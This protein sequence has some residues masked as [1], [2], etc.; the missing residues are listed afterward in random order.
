[1]TLRRVLITGLFAILSY[2]SGI[3]EE[4]DVLYLA[5]SEEKEIATKEGEKVIVHGISTDSTKSAS[6][7]N[8]VNFDGSDFYLVTFASDLDQFENGEPHEIYNEKRIAVEGVISIYK[9]KPQIKLT[10]PDQILILAD[11]EVFPPVK[12]EIKEAESEKMKE[13]PLTP[14]EPKEEAPR[15]KPPVDWKLYFK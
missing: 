9:G 15:P 3:S 10:S 14:E 6:G 5:A 11:D 1:M 2:S 4:D 13:A 7:T 8:Y 12:E